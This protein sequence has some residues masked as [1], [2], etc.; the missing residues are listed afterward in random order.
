MF[1]QNP[2]FLCRAIASI[3]KLGGTAKCRRH[4][5]SRGVW[6]CALWG[7]VKIC[8]SE[9]IFPGFKCPLEIKSVSK[10]SK[11]FTVFLRLE[12]WGGEFI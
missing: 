1:K 12:G 7:N 5:A 2:S 10:T 11:I 6:G 3:V 4:K 8:L 9:N